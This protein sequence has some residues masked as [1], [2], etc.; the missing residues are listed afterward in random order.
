M[1]GMKHALS[2]RTSASNLSSRCDIKLFV[3]A[4][5]D[6]TFVLEGRFNGFRQ[7]TETLPLRRGFKALRL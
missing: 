4:L 2:N 7:D 3:N 1:S 6:E 5:E